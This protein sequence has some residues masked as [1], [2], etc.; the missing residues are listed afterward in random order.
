MRVDSMSEQLCHCNQPLTVVSQADE[1]SHHLAPNPSTGSAH[2]YATPPIA[3]EEDV[4]VLEDVMPRVDH[5]EDKVSRME[6]LCSS[7]T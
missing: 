4:L 6:D 7:G 1:G 3:K 5:A 2:S